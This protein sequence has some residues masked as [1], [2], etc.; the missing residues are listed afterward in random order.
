[1]R[2]A[3]CIAAVI[4]STS[5]GAQALT[6]RARSHPQTQYHGDPGSGEY[7]QRGWF[8]G[9]VRAPEVPASAVSSSGVVR[10]EA[11]KS[12]AKSTRASRPLS[13]SAATL[14]SPPWV[15]EDQ[16]PDRLPN[17]ITPENPLR[18]VIAGGGVGGLL[19]AKYMKMQGFDVSDD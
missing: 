11:R 13:M 8:G 1:M 16:K 9:S 5:M 17:E 4:G 19:A 3:A 6:L 18:V 15:D 12:Q 10:G 7:R 14:V 2:A